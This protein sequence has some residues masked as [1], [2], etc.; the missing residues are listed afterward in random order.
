M[1]SRTKDKLV[2]IQ[3]TS[4]DIVHSPYVF[5]LIIRILFSHS[6]FTSRSFRLAS[7]PVTKKKRNAYTTSIRTTQPY[8]RLQL[9]A[10][11]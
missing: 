1:D 8:A 11:N 6:R 2:C 4:E 3:L 10:P 7:S 9:Q 5:P